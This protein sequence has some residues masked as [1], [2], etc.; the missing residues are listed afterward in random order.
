MNKSPST[1]RLYGLQG[2]ENFSMVGIEKNI[3]VPSYNKRNFHTRCYKVLQC[4]TSRMGIRLYESIKNTW[5]GS[6]KIEKE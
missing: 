4:T 3:I 6:Y 5:S 2:V 1:T